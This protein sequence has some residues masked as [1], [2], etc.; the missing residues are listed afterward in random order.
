MN[1][2]RSAQISISSVYWIL[3]S[4]L[5]VVAPHL[6]R[7]PALIVLLCI[8]LFAWRYFITRHGWPKPTWLIRIALILFSAAT[9]FA[10]YGT[11]IGR[12]PGVAL[13]IVML[14][15]KLLEMHGTRDAYVSLF[16]AYFLVITHFLYTQSLLTASYM[17][18]AVILITAT[19][20]QI[21]QLPDSGNRPVGDLLKQSVMLLLQA[22]PLMLVFFVLF[23]RANGPIW[24]TPADAQNAQTG[25]SD[26]M[27]PGSVSALTQSDA[28][29]FRVRF[30]DDV[31]ANDLQYWRGPVLWFTDGRTWSRNSMTPP[32]AAMESPAFEA[33]SE[34]LRYTVTLEP[35]YRRWLFALDLPRKLTINARITTDFQLLSPRVIT[36]RIRYEA[37]SVLRY[38]VHALTEQQRQRALQYPQ[39]RNPRL[40]RLGRQWR[41]QYQTDRHIVQAALRHFREEPYFYTLT[42][43]A[44]AGNDPMDEFFFDVRKGFCEHYAASFALLMRAAGI[45]ARVILGYQGGEHN[46]FGD[47]FIVRQKDAHAWVEVWLDG[48]GWTRFDPTAAVAPNRVLN[49]ID[50]ATAQDDRR[51]TIGFLREGLLTRLLDLARQ[52][53][54]AANNGWNQ[55]VLTYNQTRQSRLFSF[56]GLKDVSLKWLSVFFFAVFGAMVLLA[57][58]V[59]LADTQRE[60]DPVIRLWRRF[61]RKTKPFGLV[62]RPNEGPW[63]YRN[64]LTARFPDFQASIDEI[65]QLYVNLRYQRRPSDRDLHR[66]WRAVRHFRPRPTS[67]SNS[68]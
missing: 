61:C 57:A 36:K 5:I 30:H 26:Q 23:P 9:V 22:V 29:A 39:K 10:A 19:L 42:P 25:L 35:H 56:L 43:P 3:G 15:N 32:A 13:L 60:K 64:R 20:L 53:W 24:A 37:Q 68:R 59:A 33:L 54:D 38:R 41:Q 6:G 66:L 21:N 8:W 47:Y 2:D 55:W 12:D 31:P 62:P 4:L 51:Q 46:E 34:P 52:S 49:G 65:V 44:L 7:L 67:G 58:A 18:L 45:P 16:I 63:T 28:I 27:N 40:Y 17:V 48:A 50:A 14:S 1:T 11:I